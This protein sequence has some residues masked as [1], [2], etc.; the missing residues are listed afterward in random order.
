MYK[1]VCR[2]TEGKVICEVAVSDVDGDKI[3]AAGKVDITLEKKKITPRLERRVTSPGNIRTGNTIKSYKSAMQCEL[4]LRKAGPEGLGGYYGLEKL[5]KTLWSRILHFHL[6][7]RD[8]LEFGTSPTRATWLVI[9]AKIALLQPYLI[10]PYLYIA[11]S[12][13]YHILFNLLRDTTTLYF[14]GCDTST[15]TELVRTLSVGKEIT[16]TNSTITFD[17]ISIDLRIAPNLS[18]LLHSFDVDTCCV[19]YDGTDLWLTH[20]AWY[21]LAKG[22]NTLDLLRCSTTYE[23]ELILN[24]TAVHVSFL[25]L[26]AKKQ[27]LLQND[28]IDYFSLTDDEKRV[29][30]RQLSGLDRLLFASVVEVKFPKTTRWVSI[31][32]LMKPKQESMTRST[33][34]AHATQITAFVREYYFLTGVDGPT[35]TQC[36]KR[37]IM[38]A[39]DGELRIQ[40]DTIFTEPS[41]LLDEENEVIGICSKTL[42]Y[43]APIYEILKLVAVVSIEPKIRWSRLQ[44]I[45]SIEHEVESIKW[46]VGRYCKQ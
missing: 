26:S 44:K 18:M 40:I 43:P 22:Y 13:L 29:F 42:E 35:A 37:F 17:N 27:E 12:S 11:G 3:T 41:L 21:A 33:K 7:Q 30:Y 9:Q 10:S 45:L 8:I 20:R 5:T 24:N 14:V 36:A 28:G 19:G 6:P 4:L 16:R 2:D 46:C 39:C 31:V 23:E 25:E 1:F 15:A 38:R 34:H 32:D